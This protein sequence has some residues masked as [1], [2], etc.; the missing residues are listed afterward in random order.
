MLPG[1][2]LHTGG[3]R[4]ATGEMEFLHAD[5]QSPKACGQTDVFHGV[6]R[7]GPSA[8]NKIAQVHSP[9]LYAHTNIE[10]QEPLRDDHRNVTWNAATG[11]HDWL[12]VLL[13]GMLKETAND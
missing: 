8:A 7:R 11:R 2:T 12:W 13:C 10:H 3:I 5:P 9:L 6:F 1:P 4:S